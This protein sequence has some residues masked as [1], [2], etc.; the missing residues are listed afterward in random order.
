MVREDWDD[1][2]GDILSGNSLENIS[3]DRLFWSGSS[4]TLSK[5]KEH[6]E[7]FHGMN[8]QWRQKENG[9]TEPVSFVSWKEHC[10]YKYLLDI[11]GYSWGTRTKFILFC[12]R[13]L[14]ASGRKYWTWSC[15]EVLR[16][17]LHIEVDEDFEDLLEKYRWAEENQELAFSNAERLMKICVETFSFKNICARAAKLISER[18]NV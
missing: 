18:I 14:F 3:D 5:C 12:N 1:F 8:M 7:F 16:H 2:V 15:V 9:L 17:G 6:P 13:P 11:P 10:R 4:M